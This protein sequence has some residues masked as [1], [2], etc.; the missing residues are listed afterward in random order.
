MQKIGNDK[1]SAMLLSE[2]RLSAVSLSNGTEL[3]YTLCKD[4]ELG[5]LLSNSGFQIFSKDATQTF[6]NAY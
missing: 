3:K 4:F 2:L 5:N 1:K 6:L